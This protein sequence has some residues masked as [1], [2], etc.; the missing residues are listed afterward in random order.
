MCWLA[1]PLAVWVDAWLEL[2]TRHTARP[3]RPFPL[4]VYPLIQREGAATLR[5]ASAYVSFEASTYVPAH[6]RNVVRT[7]VRAVVRGLALVLQIPD[8]GVSTTATR[9]G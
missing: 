2:H 5:L 4:P 7:P 8:H 6:T 9:E 3:Q 1:V